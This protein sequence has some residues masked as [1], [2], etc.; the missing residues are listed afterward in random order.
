MDTVLVD[1]HVLMEGRQVRSVSEPRVLA[2]AEREG[3]RMV[4]VSGVAPL[5]GLPDRFWG[6]SRY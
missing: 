3:E 5:M 4:E 6:H 1:G 2:A